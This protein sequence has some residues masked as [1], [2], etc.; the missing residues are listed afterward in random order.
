MWAAGAGCGAGAAKAALP[1]AAAMPDSRAAEAVTA[2]IRRIDALDMRSPC[3]GP[4]GGSPTTGA[5]LF[6]RE[7]SWRRGAREEE[8]GQG[9]FI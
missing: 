8:N 1:V 3:Y 6:V 5:V 4:R 9:Y 2:A 7:H